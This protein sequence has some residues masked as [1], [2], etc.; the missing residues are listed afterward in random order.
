[1]KVEIGDIIK[2]INM[3]KE[4]EYAGRIGVVELIDDIGQIHGS[5]GGC[6][7]I[8]EVDKFEIISKKNENKMR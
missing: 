1:M 5:W 2:I 4:L 8:P 7:I 3:K 6:A